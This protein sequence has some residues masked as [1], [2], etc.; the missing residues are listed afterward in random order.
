MGSSLANCS[1]LSRAGVGEKVC[2]GGHACARNR[3]LFRHGSIFRRAL[4]V[5]GGPCQESIG[6]RQGSGGDPA[7]VGW[8]DDR[9]LSRADNRGP[10]APGVGTFAARAEVGRG[11]GGSKTSRNHSQLENLSLDDEHGV[12]RER[13]PASAEAL[14][15]G[16]IRKL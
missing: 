11:S 8:K 16:E 2:G 12:D 13:S 14:A 6:S 10:G 7:A 4:C 15:A 3:Y 1:H 9:E 5:R